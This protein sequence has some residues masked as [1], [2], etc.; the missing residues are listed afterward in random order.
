MSDAARTAVASALPLSLQAVY[1]PHDQ[2]HRTS[3]PSFTKFLLN[4][5][6]SSWQAASS[7]RMPKAAF[8][9]MPSGAKSGL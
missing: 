2:Q 4:H 9:I 5:S 7:V 1:G 3:C 8:V 6:D